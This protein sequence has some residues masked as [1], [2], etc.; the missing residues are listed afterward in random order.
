MTIS[1][2]VNKQIFLGNGAQT[3]FSFAFVGVAAADIT[4]LYTDAL[5]NITTLS[6]SQ[7]TLSLNTNVPGQ[8]WGIGGTVVYP[9]SGSPI[10]NGT[11]L[12]VVRLVPELQTVALS[13]QGAEFP[14]AVEQGLD[15]LAMQI[16]QLQELLARTIVAPTTDPTAPLPL[17]S[18]IQRANL[19]FLFDG[20]GNPVAGALPASGVISAAMQ[21][22]VNAATIA[23]GRAALFTGSARIV[24]A[25]T[26]L[27]IGVGDY[28][29]G[30][31]RTGSP[32]P[33]PASLPSAA[34]VG[35]SFILEDLAG[36]FSLYNVTVS[37]PGGHTIAGLPNYV[38]NEDYQSSEFRYYGGSIWGVRA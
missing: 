19:A 34:A 17:P 38:L 7:Y 15:L 35:Q 16:Q 26:P 13:N 33:T 37:P 14:S 30:L 31:Q 25:S 29:I 32:A 22:V 21:P 8:I 9:L 6:P 2:A 18:S 20:N 10:A 3:V 24:V 36:N 4:V 1:S 12:T 5:G 11:S 23:L 27:V 28:A